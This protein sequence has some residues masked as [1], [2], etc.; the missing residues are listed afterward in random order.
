MTLLPELHDIFGREATL[1]FLEI[2]AGSTLIV[3][4]IDQLQKLA[5]NVEIYFRLE[6][7]P[8]SQHAEVVRILAD[9]FE[10]SRDQV[11]VIY[12]KTKTKFE[13][14]LG[15]TFKGRG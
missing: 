14:E 6:R 10:I 15:C 9:D 5:R 11:R 1:R 7:A 12:A 2:F 13:I 8:D 3:P 4:R